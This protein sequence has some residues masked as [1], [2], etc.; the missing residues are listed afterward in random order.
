V[1]RYLRSTSLR[2]PRRWKKFLRDGWYWKSLAA[3]G[4]TFSDP[5]PKSCSRWGINSR[6]TNFTR[7]GREL[8]EGIEADGQSWFQYSYP[9]S[10]LFARSLTNVIPW[11]RQAIGRKETMIAVYFTGRKLIILDI[12]PKGSKFNQLYF[13]DYI[14]PDLKRA[15]L[16]FHCPIPQATFGVHKDDLMCHN[17]SKVAVKFQKN[18]LPR[19]SRPSYSPDISISCFRSLECWRES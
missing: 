8:F 16:N 5:R 3:L 15:N 6:A 4:A 19:L 13:V 17:E 2:A 18:H 12:W 10:K 1:P 9:S 14:F 11:T 7:V